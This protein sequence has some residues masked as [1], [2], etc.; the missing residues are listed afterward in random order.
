[1]SWRSSAAGWRRSSPVSRRC[2]LVDITPAA[3]SVLDDVLPAIQQM[4]S[5]VIGVFDDTTLQV[6]LET[7]AGIGA[8]IDD[9][10]DCQ[11]SRN[12]LFAEFSRHVI[13]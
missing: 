4:A 8:A 2:V 12:S 5:N 3:Q 7:L 11:P 10:P 13:P 1:M 6:L 9:A